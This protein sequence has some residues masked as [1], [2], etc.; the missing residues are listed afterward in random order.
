[1]KKICD[2][3]HISI[4]IVKREIVKFFCKQNSNMEYSFPA[5]V[6]ALGNHV[7]K[8]T[9]SEEPKCRDKV[10][11]DLKTDEKS[12]EIDP[13]CCSI[14]AMVARPQQLK[15]VGH[16]GRNFPICLFLP[17]RGKW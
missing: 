5:K 16:F 10:L 11:M 3:L 7:Y 17:E 12:I 9:I 8:N 4:K 14:K 1:M 15:A 6:A 2:G 13:Y